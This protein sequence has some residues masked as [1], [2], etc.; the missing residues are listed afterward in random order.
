MTNA[1]VKSSPADLMSDSGALDHSWRLAEMFAR[2]ELIPP[3]LR[4]KPHDVLVGLAMAQQLGVNPLIVLQS[5]YVINGRA[6]WAAQFMIACVNA[7]GRFR[8]PIRWRETG[9]VGAPDYAVTAY[10]A[11]PDG[12]EVDAT[13]S[14][15][16]AR[17][18]GWTRNKKYQTMAQ[19]MLRLRSATFLIR[20]YAPEVMLGLHTGDELED[21]E[22]A[23]GR[24]AEPERVVE[25]LEPAKPKR[26]R[27]VID[28][29][30]T[31]EDLALAEE[32][33]AARR[34]AEAQKADAKAEQERADAERRAKH[35]P[36]WEKDRAS[37]FGEVDALGLDGDIAC[38]AIER[39][40]K[41]VRPSAMDPIRRSKSLAWLS[42][43]AGMAVYSAIVVERQ[44]V[45]GVTP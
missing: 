22:A 45:P 4:G 28:A 43:D 10:A 38:L 32:V 35:H 42:T 19:H 11:L 20:L 27:K 15:A 44:S 13:V 30:P 36:S 6:G 3:H 1:L 33:E 24:L 23:R 41:G 37:F 17:E 14:M 31:P 34:Q 2:S 12:G 8:G 7:S 5:I 26:A 9:E 21:V 16:M 39:T 18:E 40:A 25:V 29:E